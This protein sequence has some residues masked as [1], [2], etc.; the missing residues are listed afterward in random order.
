M[1]LSFVY[2]AFVSV[3]RLLAGRQ[4]SEF[5][6][7]VE[8]LALRHELA[9]LRR[10]ERGRPRLRWCDRALLAGLSRFCFTSAA[11]RADGSAPD[12]ASLASGARASPLGT[13]CTEAVRTAVARARSAS[14]RS[15]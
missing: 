3:L 15:G 2:L 9:V 1:V 10:Q 8:L 4:R 11:A 6:K 12:V 13:L 7:D 5:T 14:A